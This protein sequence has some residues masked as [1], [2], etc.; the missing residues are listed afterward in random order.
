M[1]TKVTENIT[2]LPYRERV[3]LVLARL[4]ALSNYRTVVE[5]KKPAQVVACEKVVSEWNQR[6]EAH[7][8]E[9]RKAHRKQLAE[10]SDAMI[11][12]DMAKAVELLKKLGA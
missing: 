11:V 1:T 9:Q 5:L 6:N 2:L 3:K 10:V 4:G 8:N 12:G 7:C